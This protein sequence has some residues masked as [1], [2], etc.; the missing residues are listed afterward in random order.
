MINSIKTSICSVDDLVSVLLD[1]F[2]HGFNAVTG[3][4]NQRVV[5]GNAADGRHGGYG[6]AQMYTGNRVSECAVTQV[7]HRQ[8]SSGGITQRRVER[9][10]GDNGHQSGEDDLQYQNKARK[11]PVRFLTNMMTHRA[12]HVVLQATLCYFNQWKMQSIYHGALHVGWE[13]G[14]RRRLTVR[15]L[16]DCCIW[17]RY[18]YRWGILVMATGEIGWAGCCWCC[19]DLVRKCSG[20]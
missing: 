5:H 8:V 13:V 17:W 14:G 10:S 3:R 18:S 6:S 16:N 7:V 9:L 15:E 1:G 12:L 2:V 11:P 19:S 4:V 20:Q